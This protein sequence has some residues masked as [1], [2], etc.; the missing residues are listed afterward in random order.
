MSQSMITRCPK[1]S[2]TFRV[3]DDVLKMAKG[4]VRCGQCFHIFS[5][6]AIPP[7]TTNATPKMAQ[8]K[9]ESKE[10]PQETY[11][12]VS[13]VHHD[14]TVNPEWLD[15]LFNESDLEP[16]TPPE[17]HAEKPKPRK[18]ASESTPSP[19]QEHSG[20]DEDL[21]PWEMELA[22]IEDQF[23]ANR[24]SE[25]VFSESF[26]PPNAPSNKPTK[27]NTRLPETLTTSQT[28][29]EPDYMQA[30]HTLAS[31]I[32]KH[33]TLSDSEY[34]SKESMKQL[35]AEYSLASLT[36]SDT[37]TTDKRS[38][39]GWLW[40]IAVFLSLVILALQVSLHLFESG[41]RSSEF[42][43]FYRAACS[44]IG[45]TLPAFEDVSKINIEHV[46]VQSHPTQANILQV[47]AIMTNESSFAQPMPKLAL[48]FYDLN[49]K[50]VAAR[51]FAPRNYLH[52]DF[53]DITYMP[54]NTPIHIVIPIQ[55]PGAR[56]VTHQIKA[57]SSE[58]RSY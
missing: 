38:R 26:V 18:Q 47:N 45:C 22:E 24:P 20:N 29:A 28:T 49:G 43:G 40:S 14:G 15:T 52:K 8:P 6:E 53:L 48:E 7:S 34:S 55:D 58:T 2:T 35:A 13:T 5:A 56:A 17:Q 31:D 46:R 10:T 32:S 21:A 44:Y 11:D 27:K 1:C 51:L 19:A 33:D 25:P 54:P 36:D 57:F 12:E 39:Y 30:L 23:S 3:T 9:P 50:P 42:R 37:Y 16:Y 4:K 41:S